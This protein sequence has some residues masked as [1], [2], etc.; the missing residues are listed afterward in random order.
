MGKSDF[1]DPTTAEYY[2]T[3]SRTVAITGGNSG[4][5]WY[6]ILHLYLHGYKIYIFARNKD[7][8]NKAIQEI[9]AEAEKRIAKYTEL[10]K[11]SRFTGSFHH[12]HLDLLDLSSIPKA[13][14]EFKTKEGDLS[15]LI[16]N[17]GLLGVPYELTK[18]GYEI[19]Y[20][21]NFV[22][23]FLLTLLL[24]P[25]LTKNGSNPPR[26][27]NVSSIGHKF[28]YKYFSPN[29]TIKYFP[30]SVYTWVRYA[31]AKGA[32]IQITQVLA[33][34]FK[35]IITIAVHPGLVMNTDLYNHSKSVPLI[36]FFAK[37]GFKAVDSV[38]GVTNEEGALS[39]L[40]AALDPKISI[41]DSSNYFTTG[42][43][44]AKPTSIVT[45]PKNYNN[46][47]SVVLQQLED[48]GFKLEY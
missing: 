35:D 44:K 17:A 30:S 11:A 33:E 4:L 29:D 39:T 18:D 23:H 31:N 3:D 9:T 16:N 13:V 37:H 46:T 20:Q 24:I 45:N 12:I 48:K 42:G 2:K 7:K 38:A 25:L 5:G 10:E 36:G 26:I 15:I 6:T 27:I 34:K 22:G 1:F 14:D 41:S 32:Q 28:A 8:V 43:I 21:V 47:W 19:T 40:K